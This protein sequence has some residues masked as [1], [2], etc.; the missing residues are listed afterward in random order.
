MKLYKKILVALLLFIP[1]T[2]FGAGAASSVFRDTAG[3]IRPLNANDF[4]QAVFF[5]GTSLTST[6]TIPILEATNRFLGAGLTDCDA[7]N[8]FLVWNVSTWNF[9]CAALSAIGDWTGTFDGQEG[10]WYRDRANHTGTQV[11]TTISDFDE[12][13]QDAV[14][15]IVGDTTTID[16]SY[17]DG[18]PSITGI[19]VADSIGDT[20]LAF[21]TGQNLTTA[22][23]PSFTGL[24]IGTLSGSLYGV[25]GVVKAVATS[26]PTVGDGL[27]Y[28]GTMGDVLGGVSG[29]LTAT[30]GTTIAPNE[31]V[32]TPGA[33]L[34][35]YTNAAGTGFAGV[36]TSS[37]SASTGIGFTGTPGALVGGTALTITNTGVT[38]LAATAPINVSAATGAITVSCP[39][40]ASTATNIA[41]TSG[42]TVP[43][44]PYYTSISPTIIGGVS[45]TSAT[46]NNG[47][48]GTLTT[49]NSGGTQT[50]GLAAI[51]ANSV[52]GNVT[53]GSAVPSA[54]ATSSLY[55]GSNGQVLARVGGTWIG[56]ATTTAGTGL[57]YDGTSFN[58]NATGDWT[59]T[60]D[61]NN[62]A[63]GAVAQGDLLYGSA[64]GTISE[65]TKDANATRYLSN[66]GASN[67]PAWAQI[68]LTNGVT[69]DLPFANLAQVSANSVLGNITGSTADAASIATSSLFA[70]TNGQ[71][72][73]RVGGT[74][75]GVATTT[76][77]TGLT[78]TGSAF[79]VNT[80]QNISTLS[81]LTSNGFV[82]TSGGTG[83]LSIQTFPATIAQGGTNATGFTTSGNGVYW[84][85]TSLLTAPLTSAVTTPYASSTAFSSTYA[86]STDLRAGT[87]RINGIADGCLTITSGVVS[88][89]GAA[90]GG[91]G[92]GS[93]PFTHVSVWGQTTSA[94]STLIALTG[95]P[96]SLAA[97]STIK[98]TNIDIDPVA[99]IYKDSRLFIYASTTNEVTIFGIGA[100]GQNATTSATDLNMV[101]IGN[102]ALNANTTGASNVAIGSFAMPENSTGGS[103][104]GIGSSVFSNFQSGDGNVAIGASSGVGVL[105]N[106]TT[107][108][109]TLVGFETGNRLST[110]AGQNVFL[111]YQSGENV[112]TGY[113]NTF[114]GGDSTAGNQ[115]TGFG[116]IAIG[117]NIRFPTATESK[118]LNIGNLIF[119][120]LPAT[121]TSFTA[122]GYF[123]KVGIGT[124]TPQWNLQLGSSTAPQLAL[125]DG[126]ATSYH[127]VF[128]NAGGNLYIDEASPSTFATSSNPLVTFGVDGRVG[129]GTS[130]PWAAFSI[131]TTSNNIPLFAIGT[132]SSVGGSLM[133]VIATTTERIKSNTL[134]NALQS[135]ESGVSVIIGT[136]L[137]AIDDTYGMA[138]DQ[139]FVNGTINSPWIMNVCDSPESQSATPIGTDTVKWCNLYGA[140]EDSNGQ[141]TPN[142]DNQQGVSFFKITAGAAGT[143]HA[144]GEGMSLT[145][146]SGGT[147]SVGKGQWFAT[148]TPKFEVVARIGNPQAATSTVAVIGY[149]MNWFPFSSDTAVLSSVCGFVASS[150]A[151]NWWAYCGSSGFDSTEMKDTGVA[152]STSITATG[153]FYKFRMKVDGDNAFFY[154][155]KPGEATKLVATLNAVP[156][157]TNLSYVFGA[158]IGQVSAGGGTE[159]SLDVVYLKHWERHPAEIGF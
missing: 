96:I 145:L 50:I 105:G 65:L 127:W 14:G 75:I 39:S 41:T 150:T 22:S 144:A 42:L 153:D 98:A 137:T 86:S 17:N 71:V 111:G 103:N 130:S 134:Y 6:S 3:F 74:W 55:T 26:T 120:S 21:N 29:T 129:I 51:A 143:T 56:V 76:A 114:I 59:G 49:F 33:N 63:G 124:T 107:T 1:I 142:G 36:A 101:A 9:G 83:A 57:T 151:A 140:G 81:N 88:G 54:V 20:Q 23:S 48:T 82:I 146:G 95:S 18:T 10:S 156:T 99:G 40:C 58:L 25:S 38:S 135:I 148:S 53:G 73:A 16:L 64:A 60:I 11:S 28:S 78:Y 44:V 34:S 119:G 133:K 132:S 158:M 77:G 112:T 27:S 24:T 155:Q 152:S 37:V 93:D 79:N 46:I 69:G 66:T 113:S 123:G 45:T 115:S 106:F 87:L 7:T 121:T 12:A 118:Y 52:L 122:S 13:A 138:I 85:G 94:T 159:S 89:T 32:G 117:N 61:G 128:R 108:G 68:D 31:L 149:R 35:L 5:Q 47:L 97:S 2:V 19:V 15:G 147:G 125:S 90:C 4:I 126:S 100:G 131:S 72:L 109:N 70:G 67:N 141:I 84:N 154:I 80:S 8:N 139:L 30:L 110:G 102:N 91:A 92:G 43:Q 62:F 157:G 116:N 104:V 136:L